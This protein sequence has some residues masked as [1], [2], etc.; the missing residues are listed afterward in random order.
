[1]LYSFYKL[2]QISPDVT[3]RSFFLF[4]YSHPLFSTDA[5]SRSV[6]TLSR[7]SLISKKSLLYLTTLCRIVFPCSALPKYLPRQVFLVQSAM[8]RLLTISIVQGHR[9]SPPKIWIR[10]RQRLDPGQDLRSEDLLQ[11]NGSTG[12]GLFPNW[13][14]MPPLESQKVLQ[15]QDRW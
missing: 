5:G 15:K 4:P 6:L 2:F 1:M 11:A 14:F 10:L 13:I 3:L 12:V 8:F 9:Q 7:F